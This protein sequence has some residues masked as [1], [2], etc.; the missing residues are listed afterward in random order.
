MSKPRVG[1][2]DFTCCEGC[3][4]ELTNLGEEEFLGLISQINIVESRI[5]ISS[6]AEDKKKE[7]LDIACIEGSFTKEKDRAKLEE[8]RERAGIV[9]AYGAC[10]VTG[11]INTFR[12]A[13]T[14][15]REYVYGTY[16]YMPFLDVNDRALPISAVIKVDYNVP[17][18]PVD[19]YE[20]LKIV[21]DLLHGKEPFIP[22]YPV[23]ME[24][25]RRETVCLYDLGNYCLGP[26]TRAGCNAICTSFGIPCEACRG[27]L[28][29][30]NTEAMTKTLISKSHLHETRAKNMMKLFENL[31]VERRNND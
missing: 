31:G 26:M 17:G 25:K 10:A 18:C 28:D 11:G 3:Q 6:M 24:C 29:Y 14:D 4:I 30:A 5:A 1:F 13:Q 7:K 9:I 21:S 8:I 22:N 19:K 16:S 23:C 27:F 15:Y 20:F 2:F 12:D